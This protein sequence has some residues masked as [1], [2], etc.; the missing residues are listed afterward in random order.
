MK[1]LPYGYGGSAAPFMYTIH[2]IPD[3]SLDIFSGIV[4]EKISNIVPLGNQ[5]D[6]CSFEITPSNNVYTFL[7]K[8]RHF[9][10]INNKSF[11]AKLWFIEIDAVTLNVKIIILILL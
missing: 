2:N 6:C 11:S 8:S 7:M 4:S 9:F 5:V 3:N 1:K 10:W